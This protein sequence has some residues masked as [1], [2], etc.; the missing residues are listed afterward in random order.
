MVRHNVRWN[1]VKIPKCVNVS[2]LK[3]PKVKEELQGVFERTN[4]Y[5]PWDQFDP[6]LSGDY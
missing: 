4:F 3:D 6:C 5:G 2:K 1:K